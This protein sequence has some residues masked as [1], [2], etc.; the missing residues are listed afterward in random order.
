MEVANKHG[1]DD[2]LSELSQVFS[3]SHS[4]ACIDHDS[5]PSSRESM[6]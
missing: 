6:S 2:H 4:G 3:S 1:E 5:R